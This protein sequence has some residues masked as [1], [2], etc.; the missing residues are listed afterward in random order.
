MRAGQAASSG[1]SQPSVPGAAGGDGSAVGQLLV[2]PLLPGRQ[3]ETAGPGRQGTVS[4]P[5]NEELSTTVAFVRWHFG[6]IWTRQSQE[7]LRGHAS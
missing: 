3:T 2:S 5:E 1:E 4:A 7:M 6:E